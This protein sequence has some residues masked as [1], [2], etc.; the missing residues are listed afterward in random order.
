MGAGLTLR[1]R[2]ELSEIRRLTAALDAFAEDEA[3]PSDVAMRMALVLDEL[4]TNTIE[5]GY[6]DEVPGEIGIEAK[7]DGDMLMISVTDDARPFDPRK[8]PRPDLEQ[9]VEDR[10]VG[11]LG[12]HLINTMADVDYARING[13]NLVTLRLLVTS[14]GDGD[15]VAVAT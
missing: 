12:L 5:Y 8:A 14:D 9:S 13:R 1:L 4:L 7:R 11:G 15:P 10:R 6:P 3:I 2:N